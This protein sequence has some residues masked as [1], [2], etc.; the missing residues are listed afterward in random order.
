MNYLEQ[1]NNLF[2]EFFREAWMNDD[3]WKEFL[4]SM[5]SQGGLSMDILAKE[6]E[7]GVNNGHSVEKQ[8][9]IIRQ[10]LQKSS[11]Q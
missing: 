6:L 11:D 5:G 3:D 8:F 10:V 2:E 1:V 4:N 7:I 9:A